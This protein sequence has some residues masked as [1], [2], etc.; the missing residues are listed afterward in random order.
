MKK[1]LYIKA[2]PR[3]VKDSWTLKMSELFME[4]YRKNN[5]EDIV[6]ELD[7]YNENIPILSLEDVESLYLSKEGEITKYVDQF[8]EYDKYIIAAPLWNFTIPTALKLYIDRVIIVRK[9]FKYN[10]TGFESLV[11]DKKAIFFMSRGS[12][13][14]EGPMK[15]SEYGIRYLETI[16]DYFFGMNTD[17]FTFDGTNVLGKEELDSNFLIVKEQILKKSKEF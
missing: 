6:T 14:N 13:Y 16:F 1:I 11:S 15:D 8:I 10:E 7:L 4:E 3:S 12:F 9:T 5:P 17:N 2:T